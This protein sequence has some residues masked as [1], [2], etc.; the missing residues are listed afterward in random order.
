MEPQSLAFRERAAAALRDPHLATALRRLESGWQ[1]GRARAAAALPEFEALRDAAVAIKDHVL[2]NLDLYL[3]IF[4][5]RFTEAGGVLHWARDPAEA[6]AIALRICREAGARTVT[7]SK[8]MV[9]EEIGLN[10]FLEANGLEV[11]ETDLG[12]YIVQLAGEVPSHLVGPAVH[13]TRERI[14]E[15][16][17]RHHGG[18]IKEDSAELVAEARRVL[19]RR[20]LEADVGI[21]GANFLVAETG[22]IVTVT[23]EGNA[24]LTQGLPRVHLCITSIEKVVPTVEDAFTLLRLLARSATGQEFSAYTTFLTGPRRPSERDGPE[25]MHLILLDNGRSAMVGGAFREMLRCIRCGACMNHCPVYLAAG[26]HAYGWVYVGPMGSVLTPQFA[27]IERTWPLPTASTFCGRCQEVCPVRIPLPKLMRLWREEAHRRRLPPPAAR[28]GL[29]AW[30][31]LAQRPALYRLVTRLAV[32]GLGFLG[33]RRGRFSR[34][35]LAGGWTMSRD[36]PAP[37]GTT[38]RALWKARTRS[39]P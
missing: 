10:P 24:E 1:Q 14:A 6:R 25:A 28:Y 35:P 8:S 5:R 9:A 36:L 39:R 29:A 15:L 16:F 19:R 37:S 33:R 3:E 31:F 2:E 26:G 13:M 23:N 27:G 21:T 30:A 22:S 32:A 11:V 18:P 7:K 38:F 20:Y 34:L 12:E 17:A 4:E